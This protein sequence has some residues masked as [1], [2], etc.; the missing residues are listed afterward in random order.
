MAR[1]LIVDDEEMDRVLL[2]E[3]LQEAGHEPL[4]APNGRAALETWHTSAIRNT[5][6]EMVF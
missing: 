4:F 6:V 5:W 1:I 2:A 3:V